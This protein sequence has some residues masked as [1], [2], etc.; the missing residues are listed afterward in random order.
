MKTIKM[1][2]DFRNE[3]NTIS[4]GGHYFE[5][6][7]E[8]NSYLNIQINLR[9]KDLITEEIIK[10]IGLELK[11]FVSTICKFGWGEMFKETLSEDKEETTLPTDNTSN[12]NVENP[13]DN[14]ENIEGEVDNKEENQPVE[15]E[16]ITKPEDS[17][18]EDDVEESVIDV[19]LEDG[20][21]DQSENTSDEEMEM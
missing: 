18:G 4:I 14:E 6:S 3:E 1:T 11:D 5:A 21:P 12:E 2:K 13:K 16:V 8:D 10:Q 20:E 7:M 15:D 17:E 9:E 19:L